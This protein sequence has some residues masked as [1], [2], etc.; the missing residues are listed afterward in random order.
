MQ[1]AIDLGGMSSSLD[2]DSETGVLLLIVCKDCEKDPSKIISKLKNVRS[3]QIISDTSEGFGFFPTQLLDRV[4]VLSLSGGQ[5]DNPFIFDSWIQHLTSLIELHVSR[6]ITLDYTLIP[7][8]PSL[9]NLNLSYTTPS[10]E[11]YS[12]ARNTSIKTLAIEVISTGFRIEKFPLNTNITSLSLYANTGLLKTLCGIGRFEALSQLNAGQRIKDCAEIGT[13][14]HLK[15]L[16]LESNPNIQDFS[17]LARS[18][19]VELTIAPSKLKSFDFIETLDNLQA[20]TIASKKPCFPLDS[21]YSPIFE[22][23]KLELLNVY[24]GSTTYKKEAESFAK[25]RLR[26]Q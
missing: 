6:S 4:E 14:P 12:L 1:T 3:V 8:L 11:F 22:H 15:S 21:K 25:S 16:N 18:P 20:L 10:E 17:F 13:L 23:D 9:S 24:S 2:H 19:L 26:I 5:K 7:S